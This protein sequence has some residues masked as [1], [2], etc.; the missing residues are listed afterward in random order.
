MSE[1]LTVLAIDIGSSSL[2]AALFDQQGQQQGHCARRTYQLDTDASGKATLSPESLFDDLFSALD[3]VVATIPA[4]MTISAVGISTFW[5]SLIGID[6]HQHPTLPVITW[7]DGRAAHQAAAL[8]YSGLGRDLHAITGCPIHSSFWPARLRWLA[9]HHAEAF[10]QTRQW[11]SLADLLFLRLFG[12]LSTSLS[13]ASGSGLLDTNRC[14]WSPLA[15]SLARIVPEQ[16]PEISDQPRQGLLS[17]WAARWPQ[18]A[19]V[20]WYPAWGDGACSNIGAGAHDQNA[21]V[22]MLGTSGS[23]RRVWAAEKMTLPDPG[24]W[25]YRVDATRFAGGMAMSEG[26]NT[27]AWARQLM[28][29][30]TQPEID[31]RIANREPTAHGLT[32]LPYFLG[33]RSPE[34]SEGRSGAILGITAA[35]APEDIYRAALESV[36]LRFAFLKQRLDSA[37]PG[38]RRIIATGAGFLRSSLWAQIVA[39]C[40]GEPLQLSDTEEGSLRGAAL[41]VLEKYRTIDNLDFPITRVITPDL[42]AHNKYRAA[43]ARQ[44]DYDSVMIATLKRRLEELGD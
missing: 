42:A 24:L 19:E 2:R 17:T 14:V 41:L 37:W 44:A 16:L 30:V 27:A 25:C 36:G 5:H 18:L 10:R 43:Q 29:N 1:S 3:E 4:K 23:M 26:G 13:M 20:P 15:L 31:A 32:V 28:A 33:A 38:E 40:I 21:L 12:C 9:E 6:E 22:L 35:T 8:K 11:L 34:W 7:A 39:D